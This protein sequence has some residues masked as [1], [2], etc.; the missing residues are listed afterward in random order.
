[1]LKFS[2]I[3]KKRIKKFKNI[4]RSY[5]SLYVIIILYLLSLCAE[6]ICNNKPILV[7]Y[8]NKYFFPVYKIYRGTEFGLQSPLEP[9]YKSFLKTLK[10]PDFAI[11][12][13]IFWGSNESNRQ[14]DEYPSPPS[15]DNLL[16][17]DDRGRDV[18]TRL[19]YGFRISIT[20]ALMNYLFALVI[21]T[22]LGGMLGYLGGKIDLIGMRL[23]EIWGTMP[24]FFILILLGSIFEPGFFVL[25]MMSAIFSWILLFYYIRAE[26]LRVRKEEYVIAAAALGSSKIRNFFTHV[27]PN[28]LTPI[29]TFTPFIM[30]MGVLI[31]SF[32]DFLGFGVQAPTASIGELLRQGQQNFET[33]WW[34]AV[35]PFSILVLMILLLNFV[36]EG[37]RTAFDPRKVIV[38]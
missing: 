36:G 1:M 14:V 7:R 32:L 27:I 22:T 26:C 17:T 4:K 10:S 30:A 15:F 31:L 11:K 29:I 16:G 18:L 2:P 19:V 23:V 12:P 37:V 20:F 3:T 9:Q 35:F 6:L 38:K 34:L 13:F 5:F 8:N 28:A 21:G 24:Y 25:T 33:S